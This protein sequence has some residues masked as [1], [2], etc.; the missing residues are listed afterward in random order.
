MIDGDDLIYPTF[1][2]QIS[3]AFEYK[4]NLDI[5]SIY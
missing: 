2:S 4:N 1:L 3:K 5:L